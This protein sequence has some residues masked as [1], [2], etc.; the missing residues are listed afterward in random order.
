MRNP[1]KTKSDDSL[2]EMAKQIASS[3]LPPRQ[4][5]L[6]QSEIDRLWEDEDES[7]HY[8]G[9]AAITLGKAYL[10]SK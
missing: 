10:N 1:W 8:D 7:T 6:S 4:S 2:R 5:S 3:C 9:Y